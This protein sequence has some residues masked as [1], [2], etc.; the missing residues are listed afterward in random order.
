LIT[1]SFVTQ[2]HRL[3]MYHFNYASPYKDKL[4]VARARARAR[5]CVYD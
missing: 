3:K 5:A 1:N 2:R 4:C